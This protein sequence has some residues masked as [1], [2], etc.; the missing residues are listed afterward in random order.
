MTYASLAKLL[1]AP[2]KYAN[3]ISRTSP[4]TRLAI[5]ARLMMPA[6]RATLARLR[7]TLL[8]GFI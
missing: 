2:K 6:E 5:T 4:R 8:G 1:D 3:T 7:G